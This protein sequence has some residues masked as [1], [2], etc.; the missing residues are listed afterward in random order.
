MKN[1]II[2]LFL[3]CALAA[4]SACGD[5]G[6]GEGSR[7]QPQQQQRQSGDARPPTSEMHPKI[8][9]KYKKILDA[10]GWAEVKETS[11]GGAIVYSVVPVPGEA[12]AVIEQAVKI[13]VEIIKKKFPAWQKGLQLSDYHIHLIEPDGIAP[14]AQIPFLD[15]GAMTAGT[16]AW[17]EHAFVILPHYA[18]L[19][20]SRPDALRDT[21]Y[22]ESEH[23]TEY[24]NR[25]FEPVDRYSEFLGWGDTHPHDAEYFSF[26]PKTLL[27]KNKRT[28]HFFP[29]GE[30][31]TVR[32]PR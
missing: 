12:L 3:V 1:K 22:N 31:V 20:W 28:R 17:G 11:P 19:N 29:A 24:F 6:G 9:A 32:V 8:A 15:L 26:L 5:G 13:R 23:L 27:G 16:I 4:L 18:G 10:G 25:H 21:V 7:R 14:E 2:L 30:G